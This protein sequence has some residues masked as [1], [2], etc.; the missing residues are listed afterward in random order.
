MMLLKTVSTITSECFFVRSET[1]ETSST[2]S[3]F[4]IVPP[5]IGP[6][7]GIAEFGIRNAE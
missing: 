7:S 2:S 5:A 1:R 3:A 6:P 4:V